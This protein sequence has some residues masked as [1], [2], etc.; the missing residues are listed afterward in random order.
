MGD[1][2]M[3][4]EEIDNL[5]DEYRVLLKYLENESSGSN[6]VNKYYDDINFI[7][8]RI[9]TAKDAYFIEIRNLSNNEQNTYISKI[10]EKMAILDSLNTQ[11][12]FI[13]SKMAYGHKESMH[14]KEIQKVANITVKDIE[15][16]GDLIQDKTEESIVR[17]K[18][19]VDESEQMTKDAAITIHEQNIKMNMVKDKIEDVDLTVMSVKETLKEI[20]KEAVTDRLVRML[21]LSIFIVLIVL[22]IIIFSLKK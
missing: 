1:I 4:S 15:R 7:N 18:M 21:A 14:Y 3:Y 19:M 20:A 12:E 9:K 16:R 17:M 8:E 5:L 10:N 11:F 6:K 22:I 13:K 2:L